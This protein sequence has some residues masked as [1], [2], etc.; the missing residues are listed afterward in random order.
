MLN[1]SEL[2]PVTSSVHMWYDVMHSH[3]ETRDKT[4]LGWH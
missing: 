3:F 2:V 1:A 4:V